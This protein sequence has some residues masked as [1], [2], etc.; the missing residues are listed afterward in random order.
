MKNSDDCII[1]NGVKYCRTDTKILASRSGFGVDDIK[2]DTNIIVKGGG[3]G[4]S[5]WTIIVYILGLIVYSDKLTIDYGSTLGN[6]LMA[7]L[8][9]VAFNFLLMF[10]FIANAF[11][12]VFIMQLQPTWYASLLDLLR[13]S[14]PTLLTNI[15]Y[16]I[17][18]LVGLAINIGLM[19][20]LVVVIILA[21]KNR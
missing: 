20:A 12:G 8:H 1:H 4:I 17:A 14:Q 7:G 11:A 5:G 19:I 16:G 21:I 15:L 9:I 10:V 13:L 2:S 6:A 18:Q 3:I